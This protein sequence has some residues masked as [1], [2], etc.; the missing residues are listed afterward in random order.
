MNHVKIRRLLAA[1]AAGVALSALPAVAQ[2]RAATQDA[3]ITQPGYAD[4]ISALRS[5]GYRIVSVD[6][7]FLGRIRIVAQNNR[8]VREVIV[9]RS[10]GEI[11]SNMVIEVLAGAGAGGSSQ[12][13]SLGNTVGGAV[14]TVGEAVGGIGGAVG[15]A[16]GDIGGAVGDAVGGIGDAVGGAIGGLGLGN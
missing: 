9:S 16:V 12:N 4:V 6:R 7:T 8:H 15:G 5:D 2:T 13:G 1:A 11:K 10:T 14:G 3:V